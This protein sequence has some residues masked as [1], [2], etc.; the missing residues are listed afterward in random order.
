MALVSILNGTSSTLSYQ[1]QSIASGSYVKLNEVQ[2]SGYQVQRAKLWGSDTGRTMTG[3]YQGTLVG[4]FPKLTIK[5]NA[6][7]LTENDV[8]TLTKLVEQST[9]KITYYDT[10]SKGNKTAEF[11]FDDFTPTLK[12]HTKG[13]Y[14]YDTIEIV[15]VAV[16]KY[17]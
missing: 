11:Y 12:K 17:S 2:K 6:G 15:A 5:M 10:R 16:N 1:G 9:T 4:I 3:K 7:R 8:A 13:A 14:H